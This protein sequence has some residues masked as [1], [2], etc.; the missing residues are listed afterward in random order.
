MTSVISTFSGC[1]GSSL[2]YQ[3]AGCKILLAIEWDQNSV[4]TYRLNFPDTP[5]YHGDIADLSV[6]E[7]CRLAGIVPGQLD[8]LDGSPPCQGFST[9]GNRDFGDSRNQLFR[10]YCRLLAGLQPR[11]FVMENV[12]GMV[13]GKMKLIF[14]DCL[15]ELKACGYRV[16]ARLINAMFYNVPQSRQRLIFIGCVK[17]SALSHRIQHQSADLG[18]YERH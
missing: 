3:M 7:C 1:G 4:D 9:A 5:I 17:I 8:I 16:K 10:E 12:S 14:A 11:V 15:R 18:L 6:D 13:K 2:G